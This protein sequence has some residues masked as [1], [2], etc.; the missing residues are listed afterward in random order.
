MAALQNIQSLR[1][2]ALWKGDF[3]CGWYATITAGTAGCTSTI[4]SNSCW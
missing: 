1:G 2:D 3:R 4:F